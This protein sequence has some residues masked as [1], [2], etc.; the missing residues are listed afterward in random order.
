MNNRN[1]YDILRNNS[2]LNEAIETT[3]DISSLIC[4]LLQFIGFLSFKIINN[5]TGIHVFA[6]H[7]KDTIFHNES[8]VTIN[9]KQIFGLYSSILNHVF[10]ISKFIVNRGSNNSILPN[11]L[12]FK[13]INQFLESN[14]I[15]LE[16][17]NLVLRNI[18]STY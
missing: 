15:S 14:D 3:N 18:N 4:N 1:I 13:E 17:Y 7:T 6:G 10:L 2:T 16:V 12:R 8:A 5:S 11:K 9:E